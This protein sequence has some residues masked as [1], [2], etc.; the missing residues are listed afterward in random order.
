MAPHTME[1]VGLNYFDSWKLAFG[2]TG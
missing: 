2:V 1:Y